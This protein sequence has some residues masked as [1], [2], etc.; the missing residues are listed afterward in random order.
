MVP[1]FETDPVTINFA[2]RAA[3]TS[4]A[5]SDDTQ[6]D[7]CRP[8]SSNISPICWRSTRVYLPLERSI[9]SE[10]KRLDNALASS[11]DTPIPSKSRTAT[12]CCEK[13]YDEKLRDNKITNCFICLL[14]QQKF[15]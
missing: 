3:P 10:P 4:T 13:R 7:C 14:W 2:P 5:H 11:L 6:P 9:N 1:T 8:C 15:I 12:V